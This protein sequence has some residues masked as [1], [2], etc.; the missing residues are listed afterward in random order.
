[1]LGKLTATQRSVPPP[2]LL[3]C[4]PLP[5]LAAPV[6]SICR[7]GRQRCR[8]ASP[9]A[10]PRRSQRQQKILELFSPPF[11]RCVRVLF[12]YP[13]PIPLW[14]FSHRFFSTTHSLPS[15]FQATSLVLLWSVAP[16]HK[17]LILL[18]HLPNQWWSGVFPLVKL[19]L[20]VFPLADIR[21]THPPLVVARRGPL[22]S[23]RVWTWCLFKTLPSSSLSFSSASSLFFFLLPSGCNARWAPHLEGWCGF[24]SDTR[25]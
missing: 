11:P 8:Q 22:S 17:I 15:V 7:T 1:L 6:S 21:T 5:W 20:P 24:I 3:V 18:V 10:S 23:P 13:Q 12:T 4:P 16:A 25:R 9:S 2:P 19:F 14:C